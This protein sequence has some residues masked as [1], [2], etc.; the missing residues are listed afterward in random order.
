MVDFAECD[1]DKVPDFWDTTDR[2]WDSVCGFIEEIV[3]RG[4]KGSPEDGLKAYEKLDKKKKR[5]LL[6]VILHYKGMDFS[7][8][9]EV[10]DDLEVTVNDIRLLQEKYGEWLRQRN[11]KVTVDNVKVE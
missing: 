10:R 4:G 1:W 5:R 11:L 3:G 6:R 2:L 8:Q 7:Q 9:R